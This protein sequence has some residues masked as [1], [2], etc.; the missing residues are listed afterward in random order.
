MKKEKFYTLISVGIF[1]LWAALPVAGQTGGITLNNPTPVPLVGCTG[2]VEPCILTASGICLL[3]DTDL[4]G[5][6]YDYP[7]CISSVVV[8]NTSFLGLLSIP[9]IP[10]E[11]N[12]TRPSATQLPRPPP[13]L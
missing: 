1:C 8:D 2:E 4:T 10:S 13:S 5:D 7:G 11:N 6:D 9:P 12:K 3:T